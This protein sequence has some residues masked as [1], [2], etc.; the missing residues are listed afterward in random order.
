MR[1]SFTLVPFYLGRKASLYSVQYQDDTSNITLQFLN[2]PEIRSY[3]DER[4]YLLRLLREF[5]ERGCVKVYFRDESRADNAVAALFRD[6]F[7]TINKPALRLCCCR[8]GDRLVI[9][10]DGCL[11]KSRTSQEDPEYQ[12][13]LNQMQRVDKLFTERIIEKTIVMRDDG[14]LLGD[15]TFT[16]E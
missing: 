5:P 10:G 12:R 14:Q 11:K 3:I 6:P 9:L 8:Y 1:T 2:R 15:L 7:G 4:N 16:V 13:M